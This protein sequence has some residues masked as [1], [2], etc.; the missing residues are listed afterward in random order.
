MSG[1][2]CVFIL[3][4]AAASLLFTSSA[5]AQTQPGECSSGFCGTPKNNGG[6]GCG[7]GGGSI[8]VN[9][10]DLG[11]TYST[12][13]DMDGDGFE[14]NFDNCPFLANR[15]QADSDGDGIGDACDNCPQVANHDQRDID[16]DG[17]GDACD[18]D[19]DG[20]GIANA[21]DNCPFVPNPSQKDTNSNGKGDACDPDMDGDGV[22]NAIDNCPLV[23]NPD[24][25]Q[26]APGQYGDACNV[27]EDHDGIADSVDNCPGFY[28]P[29]QKDTN[30]NGIGDACD[31]DID[32]DGVPN[33][34][35]DCRTVANADQKD[36]DHDGSG[37]A[38][39]VNGY[40]FVVAKNWESACLLPEGTFQ[41]TSAPLV[42][43][44]VGE[45]VFLTMFANR[46]NVGIRYSWAVV[47]SPAG[48][49]V[50]VANPVGGVS[51]STAYEYRYSDDS[52]RPRF[53]AD[54][55]G[56]YTI[57]LSA[58]LVQP[59]TVYAG[60]DHAEDLLVLTITGDAAAS[61][62]QV[63]SRPA[64]GMISWFLSIGM[65]CA[66]LVGFRLRNRNKRAAR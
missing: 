23:A 36:D 21:S 30:K 52:R 56:T 13:D 37:N 28:N 33:A 5:S 18:A 39:D 20:D 3:V 16:G 35:D 27:D 29:D 58:D 45:D 50:T 14:D 34:I 22:P 64:G 43:A 62:C 7:C 51:T 46:E 2:R 4:A 38:C 1:T 49:K 42:R 6:G 63:S 53:S 54:T 17:Q 12:S 15:D 19:A 8:L 26:S 32:G 11:D 61:G 60:K 55:P 44:A 48:S 65:V 40:C 31:P 25:G 41:V 57:K 66:G 10:T 9:N 47:S 24:Q 59:D